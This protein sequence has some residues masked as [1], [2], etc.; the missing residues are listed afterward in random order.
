M[1]SRYG[2]HSAPFEEIPVQAAE[3][4]AAS[5]AGGKREAEAHVR[6]EKEDSPAA[7]LRALLPGLSRA[8]GDDE[9]FIIAAI[10]WF[11]LSGCSEDKNQLL[12]IVAALYLLGF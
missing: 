7:G 4:A 2:V 10:A 5:V 3:E 1:Y 8:G 12:L 6:E 9:L 11:V